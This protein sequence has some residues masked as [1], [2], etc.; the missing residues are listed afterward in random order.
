[1]ANIRKQAILSSILVYIGFLIGA[2]NTYFFTKNGSFTPE[3][4]GLTRVFYD[5]G[6]NIFVFGSIGL[7]PVMYKFYPYYHDNLKE[8][9][10]DLLTWSLVG[11]FIGFLLVLTAGYFLQPFIVQ[12]FIQRSPLILQYYYLIFLF[13][14]GLLFF[15]ILESFCWCLHKTVIS[16]FLKETGMRILVL[17]LIILYFTKAV[18]F[19]TFI[20]L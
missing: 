9:E 15:S 6:M 13:G 18:S 11:S 16:N 17:L 2:L 19:D 8:E 20:K 1:M 10:N 14:F 7:M 4:F 5:L 3:Q 12:K